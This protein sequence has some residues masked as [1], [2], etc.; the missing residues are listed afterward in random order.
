[1]LVLFVLSRRTLPFRM[2]RTRLRQIR[3]ENRCRH[4]LGNRS[5]AAVHLRVCSAQRD[6]YA[7][8]A[9]RAITA[10]TTAA[11]ATT[12]AAAAA[13]AAATASI[14]SLLRRVFV[15]GKLVLF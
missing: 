15:L 5:L 2:N 8:N 10:V 3:V 14:T 4:D 1:M 6:P 7:G 11:A 9:F 13:S 12:T